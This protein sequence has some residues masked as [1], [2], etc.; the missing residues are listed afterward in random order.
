M[1]KLE[2]DCATWTVEDGVGLL[3]LNRPDRLNALSDD[4][5][6][7]L[8]TVLVQAKAR[9]DVRAMVITGA[10]RGFSSG[11]DVQNW[12]SGEDAELAE[13]WPPKMHRVMSRLYWLPKPVVA[14]VNGVAVG[15]GCDLALAC[16]LRFASTKA[17][18]GEVYMRLGF[19]PDAGGSYLLPRIV[20]EA[21]ASEL[22]YT[23]RIVDADEALRIGLVS[24]VVEPDDL[25][26]RAM[27]QARIF[28]SGPT[29]AIGIAKEN[30][31]SG[32]TTTFEQALRNELRG[33]DLCGKTEDHVEGLKATVEKRDAVF[34]GR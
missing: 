25:V 18:F 10:G 13:P 4:L 26:V 28:A 7:D 31:R 30:I 22:I 32:Y 5:V 23:G 34:L 29:V 20:G 16:D 1:S 19:C 14:A 17:R 15:A 3:T 2:L 9:D 11:A 33:G 27:E 12:A 21:R 24:E 8:D 6:S